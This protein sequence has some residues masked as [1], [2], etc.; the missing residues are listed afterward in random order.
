M[1]SRRSLLK[2]GILVGGAALIGGGYYYRRKVDGRELAILLASFLDY[3]DL[4][5]STG[6]RILESE[7]ALNDRSFDLVIDDLLHSVGS[8]RRDV[9]EMMRKGLLQSLHERIS[10]DFVEERIVIV[11]GWILSQTEA[12][13][14]VLAFRLSR[15]ILS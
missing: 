1:S 6:K 5:E 12:R 13:L 10:L 4:A 14:C 8:G 15:A 9:P 11:D 2:A 7:A 3:P